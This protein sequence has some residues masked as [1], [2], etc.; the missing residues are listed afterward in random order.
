MKLSLNARRSVAVV[1]GFSAL[2][3]VSL[4]IAF[5]SGMVPSKAEACARQC[6]SHG[7]VGALVYSGPASPKPRNALYNAFNECQCQ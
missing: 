1:L 6:A 3:G 4:L 5:L 2:V 7:K